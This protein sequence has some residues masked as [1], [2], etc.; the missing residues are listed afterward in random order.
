MRPFGV[1]K[2]SFDK[3]LAGIKTLQEYYGNNFATN[4]IVSKYFPYP[5]KL[6]KTLHEMGLN[7]VSLKT[8]SAPSNDLLDLDDISFDKLLEMEERN[9][10]QLLKHKEWSI[11]YLPLSQYM[12]MFAGGTRKRFRCG[13][14]REMLAVSTSGKI[15]PCHRL[16]GNDALLLGDIHQGINEEKRNVYFTKDF[17]HF[18]ECRKC[19]ART[20]CG[21]PCLSDSYDYT[22]SLDKLIEKKCKR[23]KKLIELSIIFYAELIKTDKKRLLS[24]L[25]T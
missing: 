2:G 19:W 8:V 1:K 10:L 4:T 16:L 21:G 3:V 15:Y 9:L 12:K 24:Y 22:G 11:N 25:T 5:N 7:R 17:S 23:I 18:A 14:G 13:I 20:I 6:V